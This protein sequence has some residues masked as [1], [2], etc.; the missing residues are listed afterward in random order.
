MT[1][2]PLLVRRPHALPMAELRRRLERAARLAQERHHV[3]WRWQDGALEVYP[4]PGMAAGAR[5]RVMVGESDLR[6]ELHL[7][8][9]FGPARSAIESRIERK[10]DDFLQG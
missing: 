8:L 5:G 4:P 7:P 10:L 1:L 6:I 3:A 2:R 9:R